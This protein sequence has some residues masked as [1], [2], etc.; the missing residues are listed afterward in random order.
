ML[1]GLWAH[2]T[3]WVN[4]PALSGSEK[5]AA[6][7]WSIALPSCTPVAG[8]GHA[9][10]VV[11]HTEAAKERFTSVESKPSVR[12]RGSSSDTLC[13]TNPG[14]VVSGRV[15]AATERNVCAWNEPLVPTR[16][17]LSKSAVP[18]STNVSRSGLGRS[19]TVVPSPPGPRASRSAPTSC[20]ALREHPTRGEAP[21]ARSRR[22]RMGLRRTRRNDNPLGRRALGKRCPLLNP[23]F[24]LQFLA[25]PSDRWAEGGSFARKPCDSRKGRATGALKRRPREY[26]RAPAKPRQDPRTLHLAHGPG[27]DAHGCFGLGAHRLFLRAAASRGP[28][29]GGGPG[30]HHRRRHSGRRGPGSR[31]PWG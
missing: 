23:P 4:D 15:H 24:S 14:K 16:S 12:L 6:T 13:A 30:G 29:E 20:S 31:R 2:C 8:P 10:F 27:R 7:R 22:M 19:R 5:V 26:A 3:T 11:S 25:A 17:M 1:V 18:G 21:R 9:T 28:R